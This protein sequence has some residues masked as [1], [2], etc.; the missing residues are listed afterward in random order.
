MAKQLSLIFSL[1]KGMEMNKTLSLLLNETNNIIVNAQHNKHYDNYC[2]FRLAYHSD[3]QTAL[4]WLLYLRDI[5]SGLGQREAFRGLLV[6]IANHDIELA[7]KLL[8]LD[9]AQYGRFDDEISIYDKVNSGCKAAI[10]DKIRH[11]LKEDLQLESEGKDI[12]LL[13]KWMPS[14]NTSSPHTRKLANMIRKDLLLSPRQ[15]R[16]ILSRLRKHLN[17]L[18]RNLSK[19]DYKNINYEEISAKNNQKYAKL[20]EKNDSERRMEYLKNKEQ[21]DKMYRILNEYNKTM[22]KQEKTVEQ[23]IFSERYDI[24]NEIFTQKND[25]KFEI[26]A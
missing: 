5:K 6:E 2:I 13:A 1:Q 10:I 7:I 20:F 22:D 15:Y 17:I 19:K 3:P 9:L 12:S 25:E 8:R 26:N 24:I 21:K 14:I 18:E 11:L 16:K 23:I 4:R